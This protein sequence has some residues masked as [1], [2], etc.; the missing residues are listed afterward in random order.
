MYVKVELN[1][2]FPPNFLNGSK[3]SSSPS[4]SLAKAALIVANEINENVIRRGD[5]NQNE[6]DFVIE[7][8]RGLEVTF[9][10]NKDDETGGSIVRLRKD[11]D[12]K[13]IEDDIIKSISDS[14]QE[15]A[16]K[17]SKGNYQKVKK[18]SII[19]LCVEP[20]LFWYGFLHGFNYPS[21]L[22]KR[23]AFFSEIFDNYIQNDIFENVYI[24]Q[25]TE[26]KTYLLFDLLAIENNSSTCITEIGSTK[27][28]Q[29]PYCEITN[30]TKTENSLIQDHLSVSYTYKNI[31]LKN[32]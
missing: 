20:L 31:F 9:A 1:R 12:I 28:E 23:D 4:E 29:L 11:Y 15:K 24:L 27:I 32:K 22:K 18:V 17:K 2:F 16:R 30:L 14:I 7:E 8:N 13:S 19:V 21:T 6:P 3:K 26:F 5:P 10:C 25:L